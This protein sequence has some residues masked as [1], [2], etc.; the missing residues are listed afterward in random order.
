[1]R[2][3]L[4]LYRPA[5]IVNAAAYTAVDRAEEE[6]EVAL[7][8]NGVAPG[9]LAEEAKHLNAVLV[10]YSTD[11]VFD[12][13]AT[14]PYTEEETPHPLNHYGHTKLV[15][16][17]AIAAIGGRYLILRTSWVYGMRGANFML[18]M[19]RLSQTKERLTIV[20]D[21]I[22]APT[23]SRLIAEATAIMLASGRESW[24]LYHLTAAGQTSWYGFSQEIFR[25]VDAPRKV[26]LVPIPSQ[27][28]PTKAIRPKYSV[29]SNE[30]I[31]RDF[32]IALP[33]WKT[34]LQMCLEKLA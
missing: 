2:R 29:L 25:L 31:W 19:K 21:Q 13:T 14:Q 34:G 17:Q 30:K 10:H 27:D 3:Y 1:M 4:R 26:E 11:Y 23:W 20:N 28:Y 32:G 12:G 15:G 22:G 18:T 9:V 6:R 5:I 24:G 16:E 33:D 7:V 8:V